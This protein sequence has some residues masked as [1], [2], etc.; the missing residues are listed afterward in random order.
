MRRLRSLRS[1]TRF[2]CLLALAQPLAATAQDVKG[3][4]EPPIVG[5]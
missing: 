3:A 2:A 4:V 5:R 1:A